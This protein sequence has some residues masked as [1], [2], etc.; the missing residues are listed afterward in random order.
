LS[1]ARVALGVHAVARRVPL[2]KNA[3]LPAEV[4][5]AITGYT[6]L[7]IDAE[8]Y[9]TV[10]NT[11]KEWVRA[12]GVQKP[13]AAKRMM[14]T[15]S[16]L[17]LWA[18]KHRLPEDPQTLFTPAIVDVFLQHLETTGTLGSLTNVR[19]DLKRMGPI[20]GDP[21]NWPQP[22][23]ELPRVKNRGPVSR[24]E[25]HLLTRLTRDS[26]DIH[27]LA[28]VVLGFGFGI[29]GRWAHKLRG[30]DINLDSWPTLHVPEPMPRNVE[31]LE[32][33][34]NDAIHI[35]T[36]IGNGLLLGGDK[37]HNN[38]TYE[39][40]KQLGLLRGE[41]LIAAE[42][43]NRW[44]VNHLD[45]GTDLRFLAEQAGVGSFATMLELLAHSTITNRDQLAK[46]A[47]KA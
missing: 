40:C 39:K 43:R 16:R 23:K 38:R 42:L 24:E 7:K 8:A 34:R 46:R 41:H 2:V 21:D 44:F 13:R 36:T 27:L 20:L 26:G 5:A 10:R 37:P 19:D 11:V 3:P 17:V 25:E 6:P 29:D 33:Y 45:N 15:I 47:R 14:L 35:A 31:V 22:A 4:E 18:Q 9:E 12:S 32:R 1:G 28:L 30:S